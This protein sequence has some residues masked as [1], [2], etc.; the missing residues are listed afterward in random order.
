MSAALMATM[1]VDG[2]ASE[3]AVKMVDEKAEWM[4]AST[5]VY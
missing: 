1:M 3:K 5:V 4:V 2:M